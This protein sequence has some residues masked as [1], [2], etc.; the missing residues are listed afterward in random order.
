MTPG[1]RRITPRL[2]SN[3][4]CS[5]FQISD[6]FRLQI[7]FLEY[8]LLSRNPKFKRSPSKLSFYSCDGSRRV[9][10][11]RMDSTF[12]CSSWKPELPASGQRN[13]PFYLLLTNCT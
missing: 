12:Q 5:R 6:N 13:F 1:E 2:Q 9:P 8:T 3:T 11:P 7:P 10:S 4:S